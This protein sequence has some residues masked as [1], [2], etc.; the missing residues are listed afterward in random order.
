MNLS[1]PRV[2]GVAL[3]GLAGTA[4][5]GVERQLTTAPHGHVLTNVNAWSP[6]GRWLVYD[7]RTGEAFNGA[8][9]EQVDAHTGE[10]QRLYESG[11]GANC[12][13]A[14][15]S[16][17][18][19]RVV[20]IHGPENPTA[21]W[22]YHFTRR[23]GVVVNVAQP[24]AAQPLDA[25]NYAPPFVPGAL[26]GGSHVHVF[27]P[28]GRWVSF[29]YEDAVLA[30]LDAD[31]AAPPHTP[32]QRNIGV[33]VPA[34]PVRVPSSHPRNHDG[35]WFSVIVT[36]TIADPRPGSN[37]IAKAF[38]EGW[39]GRDGYVR[40]DGTHQR[41]AL[42]FLGLVTTAGGSTHAEVYLADL[43]DD[44]TRAGLAPL[45]GTATTYPAPP[46][47]VTQR[48]L[49]FTAD[50][51][52]RGVVA[53]PRHW[54][55][56]SP[57]GAQI[58]FLLQDDDDVVQL[59]TVSPNGGEPRQITHNAHGIASAFTWSPDGKSLAHVMDGSVCVTDAVTGRTERLTPRREGGAAPSATACVFSPDGRAIA[60]TR[61]VAGPGGTFAQIFTVT[62]P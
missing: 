8:L 53:A 42:A 54:L 47:G 14:T 36:R 19:P 39:V 23:R 43:P 57:D 48:R 50:R 40:P 32:N 28:D 17:V 37:E 33:S 38:E 21:A 15:Y 5:T 22:N 29:T 27:S 51:K 10:V 1:A 20:F 12:G 59:F 30:A 46:K 3:A 62:L 44:L 56:V 35:D 34:G 41:R 11:N 16:P 58:A 6:D 55:R 49:T 4:A 18:D 60:Y 9:I 25:M 7:V 2:V 61:E 24:G 45:E 13:V 52:F 26:R 31:P